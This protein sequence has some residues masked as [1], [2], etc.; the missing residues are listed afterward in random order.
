MPLITSPPVFTPEPFRLA[1]AIIKPVAKLKIATIDCTLIWGGRS[2]LKS[3]G[4]N[5]LISG[6]T[7]FI[8]RP[9][10]GQFVN[11]IIKQMNKTEASFKDCIEGEAVELGLH[12]LLGH[13]LD[14]LVKEL[15]WAKEQGQTCL[16]QSIWNII[17]LWAGG[18]PG[19]PY[20]CSIFEKA[21]KT[22][23]LKPYSKAQFEC[24]LKIFENGK[25]QTPEV[26]GILPRKPETVEPLYIAF[27]QGRRFRFDDV[28]VMFGYKSE[29][30]QNNEFPV[31][32]ALGHRGARR[33]V[34]QNDQVPA[35]TCQKFENSG[36]LMEDVKG[37]SAQPALG[38]NRGVMEKA[39]SQTSVPAGVDPPCSPPFW[40]NTRAGDP[41][42]LDYTPKYGHPPW[43][44]QY[45][46]G[47]SA[48]GASDVDGSEFTEDNSETGEVAIEVPPTVAPQLPLAPPT[49]Q[50][51]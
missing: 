5:S 23:G 21:C 2:S 14:L 11:T 17:I 20:S 29:P 40:A 9:G 32:V 44:D 48:L 8:L 18:W 34:S 16:Y 4:P 35:S 46:S 51:N 41:M 24:A 13:C 37:Q 25:G 7:R 43:T 12:W 50:D 28:T 33:R 38:V 42:N 49:S 45:S 15:K 26:D 10:V 39:S 47:V 3:G 31:Y 30:F 1:S 36:I 19:D 22:A 27:Q 6:G